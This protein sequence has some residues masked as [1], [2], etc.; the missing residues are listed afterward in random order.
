M[1]TRGHLLSEV[2]ASHKD[3]LTVMVLS[4]LADINVNIHWNDRQTP[5]VAEGLVVESNFTLPDNGVLSSPKREASPVLK[6]GSWHI[7]LKEASSA[8]GSAS[9]SQPAGLQ[10]LATRSR[11]NPALPA[12]RPRFIP[13]QDAPSRSRSPRIYVH[14]AH[15]AP[16][17][18]RDVRDA[19]AP[20]ILRKDAKHRAPARYPPQPALQAGAVQ[21]CAESPAP[22]RRPKMS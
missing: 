2:W 11:R 7:R 18:R 22:W 12:L 14:D 19:P 9:A 4:S 10:S 1:V 20:R 16:A 21:P 6:N 13:H 15:D 17:A 5:Y 3:A 8:S